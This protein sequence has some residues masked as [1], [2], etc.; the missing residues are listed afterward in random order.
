MPLPAL[1]SHSFINSHSH[2]RHHNHEYSHSHI[3]NLNG[4]PTQMGLPPT[5]WTL[6]APSPP[7]A[8]ACTQPLL[9]P[10]LEPQAPPVFKNNP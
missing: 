10:M 8:G 7:A 9:V 2:T 4:K 1:Y 6:S 3:N 5:K